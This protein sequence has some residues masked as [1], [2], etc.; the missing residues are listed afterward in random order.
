VAVWDGESW[1]PVGVVEDPGSP[2]DGFLSN[3]WGVYALAV[4]D[5]GTGPAMYAGGHFTVHRSDLPGAGPNTTCNNVARLSPQGDA[6]LPLNGGLWDLSCQSLVDDGSVRS[7]TVFDDGINGPSLH[8]AGRIENANGDFWECYDCYTWTDPDCGAMAL[9]V[10]RWDAGQGSWET[11]DGGLPGPRALALAPYEETHG[12][13]VDLFAGGVLDEPEHPNPPQR[14]TQHMLRLSGCGG[15]P[16][17]PATGGRQGSQIIA[18]FPPSGAIDARIPH[19]LYDPSERYGWT[20]IE[21][22]FDGDVRGIAPADLSL[23]VTD[24]ETPEIIGLTVDGA[25]VTV[26]LDRPIPA[27][28]WTRIAETTCDTAICLGYL[29]ADAD[30][31]WV[32]SSADI[33]TLIDNLNGVLDPPLEIWQCDTDRSGLCAS[34]DIT[35]LIDLLNGAGAFDVWN[36]AGLPGS[37]CE[38]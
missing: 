18:S 5:D 2:R 8:A 4:Y 20:D 32:S 23:T 15:D 22:I 7:L 17:D 21:L 38:Q 11:V 37:P 13:G 36:S 28:A 29:P 30:A 16:V 27:G 3:L 12:A 31:S 24:G 9:N 35:Q 10:A 26:H 25:S 6:W 14:Y 1:S 33:L 19:A 34:A